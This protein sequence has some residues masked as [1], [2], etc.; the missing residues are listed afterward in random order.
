MTKGVKISLAVVTAVFAVCTITAI[1]QLRKPNSNKVVISRDNEILYTFDLSNTKNQTIKIEYPESGYNIVEIK[2]GT[3]CIIDAD[4]PDQTCVKTGVL[5]SS[6]IPVV[7][8]PHHLVIK[9]ADDE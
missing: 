1:Y 4:C 3:I 5:K 6:G 2:D 9:Y 8:L 7:C